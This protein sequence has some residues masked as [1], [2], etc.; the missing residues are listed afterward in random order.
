MT[1]PRSTDVSKHLARKPRRPAK[2]PLEA[3]SVTHSANAELEL[4]TERLSAA[5]SGAQNSLKSGRGQ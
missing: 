5:V 3:T 4:L 1:F 2:L